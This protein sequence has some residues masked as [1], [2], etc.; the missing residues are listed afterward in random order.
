MNTITLKLC[1]NSSPFKLKDIFEFVRRCR[2]E[3]RI[4]FE[5]LKISFLKTNMRHKVISIFGPSLLNSNKNK[6]QK[7]KNNNNIKT[8]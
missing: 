1:N 2:T 6:K 7:K 3:T 8:D 5:K 4:K